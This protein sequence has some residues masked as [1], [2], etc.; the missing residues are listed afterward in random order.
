MSIPD[1]SVTESTEPELHHSTIV[2]DLGHGVG[3]ADGILEM[4]HQ[5]QIPGFVPIVVNGVMVDV[6]ED[7]A[8]AQTVGRVLGVNVLAQLVYHLHRCLLA[9]IKFALKEF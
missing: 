8:R 1:L 5:H 7:R 3:V 4:G 6:T 2:Q 9:R